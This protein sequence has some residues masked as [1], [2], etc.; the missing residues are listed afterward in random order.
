MADE[1][2][3]NP[4]IR[5]CD[6]P[7]RRTPVSINSIGSGAASP[8]GLVPAAGHAP[9]PQTRQ[10]QVNAQADLLQAIRGVELP[11]KMVMARLSDQQGVDL[12][13]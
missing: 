7:S 5:H 3:D 4:Y 9:D 10:A 6:A 8:F 12:Y 2:Q 13:L 11:V 1:P